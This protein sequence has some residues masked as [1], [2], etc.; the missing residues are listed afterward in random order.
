MKSPWKEQARDKIA[1]QRFRRGETKSHLLPEGEGRDEGEGIVTVNSA[2]Q[3]SMV[4]NEKM[5]IGETP[6]LRKLL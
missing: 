4:R 2:Q 6:V 3:I 1:N 5:E